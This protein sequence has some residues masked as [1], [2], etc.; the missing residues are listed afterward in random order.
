VDLVPHPGQTSLGREKDTLIGANETGPSD[1][2]YFEQELSALIRFVCEQLYNG[3]APQT[4]GRESRWG[5][6]VGT[7]GDGRGGK[8]WRRGEGL[9]PSVGDSARATFF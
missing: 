9:G 2:P 6:T 5:E 4:G 8:D 1:L 7:R 3:R